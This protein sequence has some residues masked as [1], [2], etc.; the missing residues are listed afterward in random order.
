MSP[1]KKLHQTRGKS[2]GKF[3]KKKVLVAREN[4]LASVA[5]KRSGSTETVVSRCFRVQKIYVY[6]CIYQLV[7]NNTYKFRI[8]L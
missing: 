7:D 6:M 3:V 4:L 2:K 8:K 5:K 1:Q